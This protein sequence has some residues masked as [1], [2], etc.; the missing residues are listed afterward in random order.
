MGPKSWIAILYNVDLLAQLKK[1]GN[2]HL[3]HVLN[4][5]LI[6]FTM[7]QL[8]PANSALQIA[9]H[10][11]LA[12]PQIKLNVDHV[13]QCICSITQLNFAEKCAIPVNLSIGHHLVAKTAQELLMAMSQ[14][15]LALHAPKTAKH[16][17]LTQLTHFHNAK[18]VITGLYL[19][20]KGKIA[21]SNVQ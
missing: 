15:T 16:A 11:S 9:L 4:A 3:S 6:S 7:S 20:Q 5:N 1:H 21:N 19:I 10:V 18:H 13:D 14:T 12:I 2:S 8:Y 17:I